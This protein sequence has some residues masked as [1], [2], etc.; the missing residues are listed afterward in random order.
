MTGADPA[1]F[2]DI[3]ERADVFTVGGGQIQ[4]GR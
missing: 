2:A 1:V 3:A 4:H